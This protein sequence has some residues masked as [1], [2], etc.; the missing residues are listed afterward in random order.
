MWGRAGV[1]NWAGLFD[2]GGVFTSPG[3]WSGGDYYQ[4]SAKRWRVRSDGSVFPC[5]QPHQPSQAED[6]KG[7]QH[8]CSCCILF[9]VDSSFK[10]TGETR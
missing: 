4:G 1:S 6:A 5:M 9:V 7:I 10:T 8:F 2:N 3:S